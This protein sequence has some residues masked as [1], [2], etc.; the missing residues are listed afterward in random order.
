MTVDKCKTKFCLKILNSDSWMNKPKNLLNYFFNVKMSVF[1][2]NEATIKW[3]AVGRSWYFKASSEILWEHL[4]GLK[5]ANPKCEH[6]GSCFLHSIY[7][8]K[9]NN[10]TIFTDPPLPVYLLKLIQPKRIFILSAAE[11]LKSFIEY[12]PLHNV[13]T[14]LGCFSEDFCETFC[15]DSKLNHFSGQNWTHR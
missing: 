12:P 9:N 15:K 14:L 1:V 11:N 7:T 6:V 4:L 3:V 8:T 2:Q 5:R 10:E 13:V